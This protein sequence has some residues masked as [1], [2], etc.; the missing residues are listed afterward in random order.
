[1]WRACPPHYLLPVDEA[2]R[3]AMVVRPALS[4]D[5]TREAC[6]LRFD[7]IDLI[8]TDHVAP[9]ATSGPGLQT[10]HYLLPALLDLAQRLGRPANEVL[11]KASSRPASMFGHDANDWAVALVAPVRKGMAMT[12]LPS[13]QAERDPFPPNAFQHRVVAIVR[14]DTLWPTRYMSYYL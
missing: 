8:A 4:D 5:A 6:L 10:Q 3:S 12:S 14:G 9:G 1:M 7:D 13:I 11:A 2:R